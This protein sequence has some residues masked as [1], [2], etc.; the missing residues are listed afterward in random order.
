MRTV[1]LSS[2]VSERLLERNR[3]SQAFFPREAGRL[4]RACQAMSE[5]FLRGG[6]A[7]RLRSRP[8]RH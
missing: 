2:W 5:R 1:A 8:L 4:A 7:T 6:E 3:I